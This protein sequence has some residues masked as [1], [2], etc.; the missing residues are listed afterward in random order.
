MTQTKKQFE[1][2]YLLI[3]KV[4]KPHGLCGD[5]KIYCFSGQPENFLDYK[6]LSFCDLKGKHVTAA[7]ISKVRVQGKT[8]VVK[9]AGID[10][11]NQAEAIEGFEVFLLREDLPKSKP[12]EFYWHQYSGKQ[13][14][15]VNGSVIGTVKNIFHSGAQ[16]IL[17]VDTG[18]DEVMVPVTKEIIVEEKGDSLIVNL[19]EG[20]LDINSE[21]TQE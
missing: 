17:V 21:S 16:D 11:R 2:K 10:N 5:V 3:G 1:E 13:V 4:T 12:G 18:A 9:I 14:T 20:L 7:D 6:R 15:E 8:A 19:P